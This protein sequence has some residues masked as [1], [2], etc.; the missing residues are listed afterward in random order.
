ML[1]SAS[2]L[3]PGLN[4]FEVSTLTLCSEAEAHLVNHFQVIQALSLRI[5]A[6]KHLH[7]DLQMVLSITRLLVFVFQI[8]FLFNFVYVCL[9]TSVQ[10]FE[11]VKRRVPD[12]W[13]WT[14]RQF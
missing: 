3:P 6:K 11:E 1:G 10:V 13:S 12:P 9:Y 7:K 2:P 14:F 5:T 8:Y 4:S